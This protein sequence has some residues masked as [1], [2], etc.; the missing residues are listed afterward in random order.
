M[1]LYGVGKLCGCVESLTFLFHNKNWQKGNNEING[2]GRPKTQHVTSRILL[3]KQLTD[4]ESGQV[5]TLLLK[6]IW[7]DCLGGAHR[8]HF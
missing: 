1:I 8:V 6:G 5:L 4:L 7:K 3:Q 2:V